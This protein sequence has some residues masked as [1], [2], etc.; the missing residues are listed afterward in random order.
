MTGDKER[1]IRLAVLAAACM[2][3]VLIAFYYINLSKVRAD[4]KQFQIEKVRLE[5]N[6][7]KLEQERIDVKALKEWEE[8]TVSWIDEFHD[9][10]A[11]MPFEQGFRISQIAV[12]PLTRAGADKKV[13]RM[14]IHGVMNAKQDRFVNTFNSAIGKDPH[15]SLASPEYKTNEFILKIDVAPQAGKKYATSLV[16]PANPSFVRKNGKAAAAAMEPDEPVEPL[17]QQPAEVDP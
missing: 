13:A 6:W 14:T 17:E 5:E 11:R 12:A 15:L 3:P 8:S 2:L 4:T 1:R 16:V 10:A 7:K 9:V